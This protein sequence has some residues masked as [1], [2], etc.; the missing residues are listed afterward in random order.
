VNNHVTGR[1]KKAHT[2]RMAMERFGRV[3]LDLNVRDALDQPVAAA[4]T[5][6]TA[7]MAFWGA[8]AGQRPAAASAGAV[9][10]PLPVV[11]GRKRSAMCV[12]LLM[13]RAAA[14]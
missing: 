9:L 1:L 14:N 13:L 4:S 7:D 5:A 3:V 12:D 2:A 8:W 10:G 11:I 6:G